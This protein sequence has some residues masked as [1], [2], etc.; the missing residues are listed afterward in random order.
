MCDSPVGAWFASITRENQSC[1]AQRT[2]YRIRLNHRSFAVAPAA[3]FHR[4]TSFLLRSIIRILRRRVLTN[5][6]NLVPPDKCSRYH[7]GPNVITKSGSCEETKLNGPK[8]ALSTE[9][10]SQ[11]PSLPWRC[12]DLSK[13]SDDF[14]NFQRDR[15]KRFTRTTAGRECR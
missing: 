2:G 1:P 3:Q 4:T 6:M 13:F 9:L 7:C 15:A 11:W 8:A 14:L 5:S 12:G 10:A